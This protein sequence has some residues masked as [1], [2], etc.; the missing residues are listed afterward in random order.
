MTLN[1]TMGGAEQFRFAPAGRQTRVAM[2]SDW[3]H[4]GF[5]GAF[6][7]QARVISGTG[8]TADWDIPHLS[9]DVLK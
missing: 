3:P 5:A 1:L 6:L 4:P 8:F 9:R 7:P 2:T